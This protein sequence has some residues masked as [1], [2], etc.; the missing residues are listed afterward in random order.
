MFLYSVCIY[1]IKLPYQKL[2]FLREK[3]IEETMKHTMN[4]K[5]QILL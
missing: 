1:L 5:F 4:C 3:N 2:A